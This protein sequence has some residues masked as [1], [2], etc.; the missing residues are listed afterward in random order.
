MPGVPA[1]EAEPSPDVVAAVPVAA[2]PDVL[3]VLEPA[4]PV[5][6]VAE[7]AQL[8][9]RE[10]ESVV[11]PEPVLPASE[12]EPEAGAVPAADPVV[13]AGAEPTAAEAPVILAAVTVVPG[14]GQPVVLL[15]PPLAP[16][17]I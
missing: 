8:E 6:V 12:P 5:G 10:P 4:L 15:L 9:A 17:L 3:G 2:V 7:P 13:P 11:V 16:A 1:V 14:V